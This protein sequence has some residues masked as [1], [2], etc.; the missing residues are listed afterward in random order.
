[1]SKRVSY[2]VYGD[3][4]KNL[5]DFA[6]AVGQP[7]DQIAKVALYKYVSSV[8]DKAEKMAQEAN[9]KAQIDG[10]NKASETE[11]TQS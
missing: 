3:D 6:N 9:V 4:A 10:L 1:M 8:L 2:K 5:M 7:L 11:S